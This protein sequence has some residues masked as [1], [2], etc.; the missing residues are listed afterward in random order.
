MRSVRRVVAQPC[1]DCE[2][3]TFH[4]VFYFFA[5]GPAERDAPCVGLGSQVASG[6]DVAVRKHYCPHI[7]VDRRT[8][9]WRRTAAPRVRQIGRR[10]GAAVAHLN[11]SVEKPHLAIA[12]FRA[13]GFRVWL[14]CRHALATGCRRTL[15]L[16]GL[17]SRVVPPHRHLRARSAVCVL[18]HRGLSVP[19]NKALETNRRIAGLRLDFCVL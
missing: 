14:P 17:A 10:D 12:P 18:S 6:D 8:R 5:S 1:F 2:R 19:P 7:A 16:R 4:G 11:R 15:S 13:E 3:P 9:R